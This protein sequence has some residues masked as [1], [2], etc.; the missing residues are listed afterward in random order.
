MTEY[1]SNLTDKEWSILEPILAENYPPYTLDR[2]KGGRVMWIDMREIL[3][4]IFYVVK[5]GC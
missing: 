3:N 5:T 2:P 4:G 1:S